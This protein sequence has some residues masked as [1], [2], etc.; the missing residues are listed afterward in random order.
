MWLRTDVRNLATVECTGRRFALFGKPPQLFRPNNIDRASCRLRA[1]FA[2]AAASLYS[3]R[4]PTESIKNRRGSISNSIPPAMERE[5]YFKRH[6]SPDREIFK[7]KNVYVGGSV[8][9][10]PISHRTKLVT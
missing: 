8:R 1:I 2:N 4:P 6:P 9:S 3:E 10:R 7:D 5:R